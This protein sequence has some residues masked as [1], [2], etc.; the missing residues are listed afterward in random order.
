MSGRRRISRATGSGSGI[1][2]SRKPKQNMEKKT[3]TMDMYDRERVQSH[4]GGQR[5]RSER[6]TDNIIS[7]PYKPTRSKSFGEETKKLPV[8]WRLSRKRGLDMKKNCDLIKDEEHIAL[9]AAAGINSRS[10]SIQEVEAKRRNEEADALDAELEVLERLQ[11]EEE[12]N[13]L[14]KAEAKRRE[15]K[16]G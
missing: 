16:K 1:I 6:I 14:G 13:E 4:S 5:T 10:P 8:L 2:I 11:R 3:T 9:M 12:W 15:E 7:W